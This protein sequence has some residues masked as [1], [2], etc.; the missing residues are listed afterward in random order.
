MRFQ[1]L[2]SIPLSIHGASLKH[3]EWRTSVHHDA[4]PDQETTAPITVSFSDIGGL[5][6]GPTFSPDKNTSRIG[7]ETESRL[8]CEENIGPLFLT[9]A[10][11]LS[12]PS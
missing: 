6:T 9:P 12:A 8:V 10:M 1:D 7:L 5:V 4:S 3:V 11:M 2:V